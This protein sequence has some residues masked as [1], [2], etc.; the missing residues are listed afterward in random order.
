MGPV[1]VT[2]AQ[3][4]TDADPAAIARA[5]TIAREIFSMRALWADIEAL[6]NTVPADVQ[7]GMFYRTGRLLRHTSYWLLRERGKDLHIENAVRELRAGVEQL[8]DSIDSAHRRRRPRAARRH[9]APSSRGGGVPEKLARRVARL[10]LLEPALDIVALARS[11]RVAGRRRRARVLRTR[12]AARASTGCTARSTGSRSM[13]PGRP[14][15][16]PACAMPPCARIASSP[17]RC[18][19]RAARSA[20]A[21]ASRAGARSAA[22]ALASW[23]RTLTEM[24]AR[25]HAPISP[26]SPWASTRCAASPSG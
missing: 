20:S 19:A 8:T 14:R 2:R 25:G 11:E 1:F 21:S 7:Y 6:D 16:A 17:S 13:A 4:D 5:Y 26:R 24:R 15:R 3:E 9:V 18:C 12:R 10:A 22:D 23:K